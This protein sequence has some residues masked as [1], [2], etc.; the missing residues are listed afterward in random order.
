MKRKVLALALA[1][2]T[3]GAALGQPNP[4][5]TKEENPSKR[6]SAQDLKL[7]IRELEAKIAAMQTR[8]I[9]L[10]SRQCNRAPVV[11]FPEGPM[12][13]GATPFQFNGMQFWHL[14]VSPDQGQD[15]IKSR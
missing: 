5:A 15:G 14:H 8:I 9:M 13:P 3:I 1:L 7:K 12:P 6:E 11:P 2:L 10:E 4:Q